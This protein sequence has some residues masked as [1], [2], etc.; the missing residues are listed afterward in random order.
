MKIAADSPGLPIPRHDAHGREASADAPVADIA[1]EF[2]ALFIKT[3]L[4]EA[5]PKDF[6][7]MGGSGQAEQVRSL[8][9][10]ELADS[11]AAGRGLGVAQMLQPSLATA[12]GTPTASSQPHA[13]NPDIARQTPSM[14]APSRLSTTV[15]APKALAEYTQAS[16]SAIQSPQ[17]FVDQLSPI[18]E[19]AAKALGVSP[20]ILIAQAALETGWGQ[21]MP[22]RGP[23]QSSHN[24]FGVKTH[25][26]WSG[27]AVEAATQ[28]HREGKMVGEQAEFRGYRSFAEAVA[29]YVHFV[30]TQPRYAAALDHGGSDQHYI[31]GLAQAGYAT[32]PD[33]AARVLQVADS[34]WLADM[35]RKESADDATL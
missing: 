30:R 22:Q 10:R 29:D 9:V 19:S 34:P 26:R 15:A 13:L 2:E 16:N 1:R 5:L 21:H 17:D 28:E 8:W 18:M 32:D 7:G 14:L 25:G 33:Y 20:R 35:S 31:E 6:A 27:A 4:D 24:L 3:L 23:G 11:L 12:S